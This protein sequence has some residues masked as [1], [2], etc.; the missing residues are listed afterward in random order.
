MVAKVKVAFTYISPIFFYFI[1]FANTAKSLDVIR[2]TEL[3]NYTY[4]I[5]SMLL[6]SYELSEKDLNIYFIKSNQINAFVTGGNNIFINTELI[7]K[8]DDYREYAAVI[9]H[10]LSHIINGH[11]FNTSIEISDLSNKALPIYLL[12]I[13]SIIAGSTDSGIAGVMVGQA[14]VTDGFTYY[15]RTQ[16]AS[17]DQAAVNIL[18]KGGV[19]AK[20]LIS[21]LNILDSIQL[22][23]LGKT[24]NYR[25]THPNI[26]NRIS[27][28]ESSMK[29][30]KNCDFEK[31]LLLEKKFNLLKAKLHGFTHPYYET[32]AVYKFDNET[33]LYARAV[34]KYLKGDHKDSINNLENLLKIDPYNPYYMELIG[35][36]YFS[37]HDFEKAYLYQLEANKNIDKTNDLYNMMIGNYLLSFETIEK[38]QESIPYLK[39]SIQINPMNAYSWYL[40]ARAYSEA[41]EVALA[42]YATA[43]RYFLIG[44]R[45]LSYGFAIKAIK[46]IEENSPEWYRS[47]DLIEILEKEV[48]TNR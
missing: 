5:V 28:I 2:D 24:E 13:I 31:D 33:D 42:N 7:I 20:Y 38:T 45:A 26:E 46:S 25:S 3:E 11:I 47:S 4:E 17:A 36:I 29:N 30:N 18:C 48:S 15:S 39:K 41:N 8:S 27:W 16:E 23:D 21:F 19:D 37:N 12:G 44:E 9:A 35:E 34:S 43:E 10:E 32:E 40:L 22:N 14:S 6:K 1:I